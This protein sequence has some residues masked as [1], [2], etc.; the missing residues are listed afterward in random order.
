MHFHEWKVLYFDSKFTEVCSQ[1]SNWQYSNIGLD[2]CSAP[3]KRQ[4]IIWTNADSVRWR[5]YASLG[6]D[7][8]KSRREEV[9]RRNV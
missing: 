9:H 2:N 3:T 1:K 7:E 4:A 6:G 5:I 8:L